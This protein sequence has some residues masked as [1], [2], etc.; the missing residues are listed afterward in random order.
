MAPK[1]KIYTLS[2]KE[3][4]KYASQ[5]TYDRPYLLYKGTEDIPERR[6]EERASLKMQYSLQMKREEE[7][8]AHQAHQWASQKEK[9]DKRR[10]YLLERRLNKPRYSLSVE[11]P[12]PKEMLSLA[13][14]KKYG[15]YLPEKHKVA[16]PL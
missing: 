2:I 8:L 14:E 5:K 9:I 7:K 4:E 16:A 11:E 6:M 15:F 13:D 12:E 1:S 3:Q 10:E